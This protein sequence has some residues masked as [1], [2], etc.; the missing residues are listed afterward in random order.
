L[1]LSFLVHKQKFLELMSWQ[2]GG[3]QRMAFPPWKPVSDLSK[4]LV[5]GDDQKIEMGVILQQ[6]NALKGLCTTGVGLIRFVL[7]TLYA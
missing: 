7:S 4:N 3:E 1:Q 6:L 5:P 2:G